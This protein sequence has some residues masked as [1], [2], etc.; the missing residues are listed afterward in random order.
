M[1]K[2]ISSNTLRKLALSLLVFPFLLLAGCDQQKREIDAE[3]DATVER[4]DQQINAVN[5]TAERAKIH[6]EESAAIDR[7]NIEEQKET[8]K[9]QLEA[10]KSKVEAEA[11]AAKARIDAVNE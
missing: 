4:I 10:D 3:K 2:N 8:T 5:D 11:E 6:S 1:K 7:A 9:A